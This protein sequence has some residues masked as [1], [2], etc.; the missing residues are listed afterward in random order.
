MPVDKTN[1]EFT[2]GSFETIDIISLDRNAYDIYKSMPYIDGRKMKSIFDKT[3]ARV[4]SGE[5]DNIA[6]HI[7]ISAIHGH[8]GSHDDFDIV[9]PK[10]EVV[11]KFDNLDIPEEEF[12]NWHNSCNTAFMK[13]C[14][15]LTRQ[16]QHISP[17]LLPYM[18]D[19]SHEWTDYDFFAAFGLELDERRHII[20]TMRPYLNF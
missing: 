14:N 19:Y 4:Y 1:D 20:S 16:G 11:K 18:G 3:I 6:N 17:K 7:T 2:I 10:L 9:S 5:I 12:E 8:A 15:L 13:Y